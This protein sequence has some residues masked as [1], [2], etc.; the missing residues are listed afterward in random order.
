MNP[1][2]LQQLEGI[3]AKSRAAVALAARRSSDGEM[4]LLRADQRFHPASTVKVCIMMEAYRQARAGEMSLDDLVVIRNEFP[5]LVDGSPYSLLVEDDSEKELYDCIGRRF[6]KRELIRR[7][8]A[9]SSNLASNLLLEELG[10]TR[11]TAFMRTLG[12][13]DLIVLRGFEDKFA[14]RRGL[15]NVATARGFMQALTKLA[16]R[17]VVSPADSGEMIE[18]LFQQQFNEM[19][20]ARLPA[21]VRVAH[22]TGWAADYHHDVGIVYPPRGEPFALCILT[23]GYAEE[24]DPAAHALVADLAK[25]IYDY[26]HPS[27]PKA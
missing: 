6:T 14:Y 17:E 22:K 25:A 10:A 13:Q 12:A 21:G 3:I 5:S 19:I 11:V 9:V 4:I 27:S 1:L 23:K 24:E 20:P 7:M 16:N 8:I 26:W 18:I 15:N 2:L